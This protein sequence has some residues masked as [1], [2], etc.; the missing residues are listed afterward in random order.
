MSHG[1]SARPGDV[2][3]VGSSAEFELVAPIGSPGGEG[4]VWEAHYLGWETTRYPALNAGDV[5]ALKILGGEHDETVD[6]F[7]R[8]WTRVAEL[9]AQR[10]THPNLVRIYGAPFR[11]RKPHSLPELV[12]Q[13]DTLF[14]VMEYLPGQTLK[15]LILPAK[16][17]PAPPSVRREYLNSLTHVASG[18][19]A[20]GS[21]EAPKA[22]SG[23]SFSHR[24]GLV[25]RDVKPDNIIYPPGRLPVL[26]DFG[27]MREMFTSRQ[28]SGISGTVG[29]LAPEVSD[30]VI[31]WEHRSTPAADL[32]SF[33]CVVYFTLTAENPP[34]QH[35]HWKHLL[36][37]K[38]D[39]G[40]LNGQTRSVLETVLL[41]AD[42]VIRGQTTVDAWMARL[43]DTISGS[44]GPPPHARREP[45][46]QATPAS[47]PIPRSPVEGMQDRYLPSGFADEAATGTIDYLP[48]QRPSWRLYSD[49]PLGM[50]KA[51]KGGDDVAFEPEEIDHLPPLSRGDEVSFRYAKSKEFGTYRAINIEL[52]SRTA[53]PSNTSSSQK[54]R[55]P[56]R[57]RPMAAEARPRW[58]KKLLLLA[59]AA[60]VVG[61]LGAHL[62]E[63]AI[64]IPR[65]SI[66]IIHFEQFHLWA[67]IAI[68]LW[69]AFWCEFLLPI[70]PSPA[71]KGE[72]KSYRLLERELATLV[73]IAAFP[74]GVATYLTASQLHGS[75]IVISVLPLCGVIF[76]ILSAVHQRF[77]SNRVG[78]AGKHVKHVPFRV[79]LYL[80][81]GVG[82]LGF[83]GTQFLAFR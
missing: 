48:G 75:S 42:P 53:V 57:E 52:K 64:G 83:A 2:C 30:P 18:L 35:G 28:Y 82:L 3:G 66:D 79:W 46:R 21:I 4:E 37:S 72:Y 62:V 8:R 43:L 63:N 77:W 41:E 10:C 71:R 40:I 68:V 5:V 78:A 19:T 6:L 11:G 33:A 56:S 39:L 24:I 12:D 54:H 80:V 45:S 14:L 25:H 34:I 22:D 1:F 47:E 27:S 32:Y 55:S 36:D 31:D 23:S 74:L 38:T 50:I 70:T 9:Y 60:M 59:P 26:V 7:E 69:L 67:P 76:L 51:T 58:G 49:S 81:L 29:Y 13:G 44:G 20:L 15:A 17:R 73:S 65:D 16:N 61:V